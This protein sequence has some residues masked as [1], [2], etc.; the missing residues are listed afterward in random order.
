VHITIFSNSIPT[1][2][3]GSVTW[4]IVRGLKKLGFDVE[5][6]TVD[7]GI[8]RERGLVIGDLGTLLVMSNSVDKLYGYVVV[9]GPITRNRELVEYALNKAVGIAVP[10]SF[11]A[12][13]LVQYRRDIK[14]IPHGIDVNAFTCK[15][16]DGVFDLGVV[17]SYPHYH[18]AIALRKGVDYYAYVATSNRYKVITTYGL[19]HLSK[20]IDKSLQQQLKKTVTAILP[21]SGDVRYIYCKS[22]VLLWLSRSEGFGLPPLEAMATGTPVIYTDAPA[23]NQHTC[24]FRV[25]TRLNGVIEMPRSGIYRF[26][27]YSPYNYEI[28]DMNELFSTIDYALAHYQE[29]AQYVREIASKYDINNMVMGIAELIK[30]K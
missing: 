18:K 11:V 15:S 20:Y 21:P 29:Y 28:V 4:Y 25:R 5:L 30:E 23:H 6:R 24:C 14:L 13:E 19:L 22:K 16:K 10:S 1:V 7:P 2:G 9:E 8:R 27:P 17:V 26:V 12:S 3:F